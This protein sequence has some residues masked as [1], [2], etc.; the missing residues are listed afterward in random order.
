V[1]KC[2]FRASPFWLALKAF[3]EKHLKI[4][5]LLSLSREMPAYRRL[6]E[7]L[8][9]PGGDTSVLLLDAAKPYII[10]ALYQELLLPVLVVTARPESSKKLKEQISAWSDSPLQLF[11]EPSALPYQ[12]IASDTSTVLEKI[13]VLSA[14]AKCK[15]STEPALIVASAPALMQK[16]ID[17]SHF[18]SAWHTIK[19]GMDIELLSLLGRWQTIGYKIESIVEVPGTVRHRG[20]IIDIYPP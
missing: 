16:V 10:A 13:Q 3:G 20:G 17:F 4:D 9:Q 14:L 2:Y 19:L 7:K 8:Q 6:I 15:L 1:L 18:T 12:R 11:P 5:K